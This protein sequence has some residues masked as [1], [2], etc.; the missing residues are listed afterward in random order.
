MPWRKISISI[1][2]ALLRE[3]DKARATLGETR[4]GLIQR[5]LICYLTG[6]AAMLTRPADTTQEEQEDEAQSPGR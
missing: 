2:E 4:S 6:Q 5:L 1:D 3:C